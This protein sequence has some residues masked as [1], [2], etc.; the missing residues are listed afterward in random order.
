VRYLGQVIRPPSEADSLILQVMYGCSHGDCPLQLLLELREMI[1]ACEVT[2]ALL[3]TNHA[4][5]YLAVRGTLPQDKNR[6]LRLLDDVLAA[7]EQTRLKPDHLRG[8]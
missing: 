5:N 7:P 2:N 1:D 6:L 4:S 8:L 3:R